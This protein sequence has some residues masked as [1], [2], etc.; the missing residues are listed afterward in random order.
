M[1]SV[2]KYIRITF[3]VYIA[4]ILISALFIGFGLLFKNSSE[5]MYEFARYL[6]G[7]AQSPI[8]LMVLIP[9][10]KLSEKEEIKN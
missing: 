6:M 4:I 9:A 5:T 10:L 3:A 7:M 2:K 8:I 1:R